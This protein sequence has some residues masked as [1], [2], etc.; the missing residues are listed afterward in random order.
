MVHFNQRSS[1]ARSLGSSNT[2]PRCLRHYHVVEKA[3]SD[4]SRSRGEIR[5]RRPIG[6]ARGGVTGGVIVRDGEGPPVVPEDSVQHL[7][8]GEQ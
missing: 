3:K 7:A 8:D 2:R 6:I 5:S 1:A 4:G